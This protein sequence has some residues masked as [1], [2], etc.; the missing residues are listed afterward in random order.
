MLFSYFVFI[1]FIGRRQQN[2]YTIFISNIMLSPKVWGKH[3]WTSMHIVALGFPEHPS[4]VER[5]NYSRFFT[6]IGD[7]L[8]CSKCRDHYKKH[9]KELPIELYLASNDTL[10]GWTVA[11]HNIVNSVNGKP[12]WTIDQ[13]RDYYMNAKFD[14]PIS[15]AIPKMNYLYKLYNVFCC[16]LILAIIILILLLIFHKK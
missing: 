8:P 10:F 3:I 15:C 1:L 5:D 9:L 13:A 6:T 14:N 12:T 11:V 7:I 4:T 2:I 16:I